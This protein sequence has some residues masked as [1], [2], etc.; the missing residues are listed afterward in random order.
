MQ[1][2]TRARRHAGTHARRRVGTHRRRRRHAGFQLPRAGALA[3]AHATLAGAAPLQN[4]LEGAP[5]PSSAQSGT[6]ARARALLGRLEPSDG[7]CTAEAGWLAPLKCMHLPAQA[8]ERVCAG[9]CACTRVRAC[10]Y[11]QACAGV[12]VHGRRR[13]LYATNSQQA[14]LRILLRALLRTL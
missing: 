5:S 14:L 13:A 7:Q 3:C 11:A 4:R 8:K 2:G 9:V 12:C 10:A 1:A 6:L